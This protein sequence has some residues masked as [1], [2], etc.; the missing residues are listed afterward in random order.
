MRRWQWAMR[1]LVSSMMVAAVACSKDI[2][3]KFEDQVNDTIHNSLSTPNAEYQDG[4]WRATYYAKNY[5]KV[6]ENCFRSRSNTL[7]WSDKLDSVTTRN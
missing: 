7:L 5:G 4:A 2:D 6:L 1:L 3:T